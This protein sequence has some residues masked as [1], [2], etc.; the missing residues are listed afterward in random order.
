MPNNILVNGFNVLLVRTYF[1]NNTPKELI[2]S[3]M[4]DGAKEF[5]IFFSI[6]MPISKPILAT[7]GL[8]IGIGYWNDWYNSMLFINSDHLYSLQYQLYKLLNDAK[9]LRQLA[10]EAGIVVDTVPIESMKMAL[11][12]VVTGPIVLLYP[13]VQR[14]FIK[15]LTLGAVKG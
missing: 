8:L 13:F 10:S 11:T 1:N 9:V 12:V 2:E 4:V 5:R 14:Y 15:G 6:I 3:A 7:V